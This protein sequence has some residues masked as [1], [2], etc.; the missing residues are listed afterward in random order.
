MQEGA[1]RLLE[2]AMLNVISSALDIQGWMSP[3]ELVWLYKQA[4]NVNSVVEVGCWKGRS[5]V[6][7][8]SGCSGYVFA[9]DH[10][11]G[12]ETEREDKH[13][14]ATVRDIYMDF[15]SN[16]GHFKNL[17]VLKMDSDKASRWFKDKS[18][19]MVFIDSDHR[20]EEV[21]KEI[22]RWARVCRK[23]LCGHDYGGEVKRAVDEMFSCGIKTIGSIWWSEA[24]CIKY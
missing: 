24:P 5:T 16:V 19:D 7:L 8:L 11:M 14:E 22:R 23:L 3:L 10:F 21:K 4:L 6:P 20:Y 1:L 2:Q 13:K 17:V 15:K 9:I 12:S 18:I